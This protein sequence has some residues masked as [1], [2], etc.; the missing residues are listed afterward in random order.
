MF[1][2]DVRL[3][4]L[5]AALFGFSV[6]GGI[7]TTL[8]NLFLL[9]LGYDP[10]FAGLVNGT[11][12]LAFA[13]VCLPAAM[14]GRQWNSRRLLVAS[15]GVI[16][17]GFGLLP[18]AEFI[19]T[20]RRQWL[21]LTHI[22][23]QVGV[24]AYFVYGNPFL[25]SITRPAER[26]YVYA[27]VAALWPLTG[28]AGSLVGGLLPG[29]LAGLLQ[30]PL[31]HPAPYRYPLLLAAILMI[32]TSLAIARTRA[33]SEAE[34][35]ASAPQGQAPWDT[36]ILLS[37]TV[38]LR[39]AGEG[40]ARNFLNIYLDES[41]HMPTAHIGLLLASGQL[42]AV[43]M[44]LLMPAL[45]ARWSVGK[46]Y[47]MGTVGMGLSLLPLAL[48]PHWLAASLGYMS[49]TATGAITRPA[50][51]VYQMEIVAADWRPA[52]SSATTMALGLSWA[53]VA[54][55]G[56]YLIVRLGYPS[57]FLASAG[58]SAAGALL[59]WSYFRQPRGEFASR[60]LLDQTVARKDS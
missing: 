9:R 16:A 54:L 11:G 59:F 52:M 44:A 53:I 14:L 20:G 43:P 46:V 2:R 27:T 21:I 12:Q 48:I 38:L 28:V 45:G 31:T 33:V 57:L 15:L 22:L 19:P 55:G 50:I 42:V 26:S 25:M 36:I 1:N 6:F 4:L 56:G 40:A 18:L 34:P 10:A 17:I 41:L 7:Y 49:L 32:P 5:T 29:L 24:A 35:A 30:L 13:L 39:V 37:L 60:S 23:G 58:L 3:Y 51:G 8:L 47:T